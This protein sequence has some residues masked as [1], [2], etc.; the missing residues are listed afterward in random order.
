MFSSTHVLHVQTPRQS[1]VDGGG[2]GGKGGERGSRRSRDSSCLTGLLFSETK[3]RREGRILERSSLSHLFTALFCLSLSS[4]SLSTCT[5]LFLAYAG[6]VMLIVYFWRDTVGPHPCP[7][8]PCFNSE[9]TLHRFIVYQ[10]W[11]NGCLKLCLY[12]L[13]SQSV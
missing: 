2:Q 9:R 12:S 13:I 7:L 5:P 1:T 8:W 6:S 10:T 11:A 3:E 4:F